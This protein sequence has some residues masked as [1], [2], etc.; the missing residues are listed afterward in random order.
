MLIKW[1]W[2]IFPMDVFSEGLRRVDCP[3]L[4]YERP[5]PPG[6]RYIPRFV[7]YDVFQRPQADPLSHTFRVFGLVGRPIEV[8][9]ADMVT[10]M[11]C[12]DLVADFHC[13]TGWSVG[14][15]RWRG[16]P[17]A[18]LLMGAEPRGRYALVWGLDGYTS[19]MPIEA[20]LEEHTIAAWAMNGQPLRPEHGYPLRLVVPSRYGWKS[21]KYLASVEVL[22]KPLPGYWEAHGYTINA[23][24][25][26]EERVDYDVMR[27][28]RRGVKVGV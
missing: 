23:D 7:V 16:T 9:L 1:I 12:V 17:I 3:E 11:P 15:V 25:W 24:P 26:T 18:P 13:V 10:R 2:A 4:A 21:V 5:P 14:K 6:Q 19:L 28:A 22:D 20:L 8:G 27:R